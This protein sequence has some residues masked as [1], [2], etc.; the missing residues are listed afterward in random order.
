[1]VAPSPACRARTAARPP[2]SKASPTTSAAPQAHALLCS[3]EGAAFGSVSPAE[4]AALL[5]SLGGAGLLEQAPDGTLHLGA[6]GE[7]LGD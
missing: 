2:H 5:R 1:M 4:F 6:A 7:R 3:G